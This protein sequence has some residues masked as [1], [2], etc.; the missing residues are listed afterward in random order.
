MEECA[1]ATAV[2][3]MTAIIC[4]LSEDREFC[5]FFYS[6]SRV[7]GVCLGIVNFSCVSVLDALKSVFLEFGKGVEDEL[8]GFG[9]F[10]CSVAPP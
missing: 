7:S 2:S 1:S 10:C 5:V 9:R 3:S 4:C 6:L 8:E